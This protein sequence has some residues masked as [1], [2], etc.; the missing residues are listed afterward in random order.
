MTV[1]RALQQGPGRLE[2]PARLA[3]TAAYVLGALLV[4]WSAYIHFHLWDS[5]GY[6]TI[7]TVGA[8]FVVQSVVGLVLGLGVA[9]VRRAWLALSG[10]GFVAGTLGGFLLTV[11]LPKGLFGFKDSWSAPFARQAFGIEV[12]ALVV[13]LVGAALCLRPHGAADAP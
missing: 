11:S 8:L 13:L 5:V 7:P 1:W 4:V 2:R 6:R 9:V 10:A 12:A 3:A